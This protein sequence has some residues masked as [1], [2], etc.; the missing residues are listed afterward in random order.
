MA[1]RGDVGHLQ[2]Q[3]ALTLMAGI[4]DGAGRRPDPVKIGRHGFDRF[5]GRRNTHPAQWPLAQGR[6]PFQ[7]QG[8]MRAALIARHGVD[9]IHDH[10]STVDNMA[11]PE[12]E[13]RRI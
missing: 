9:L 13:V 3:V 4:D 1:S 5:L 10:G 7:G 8:Q 2:S 11:R 6:Q 12:S